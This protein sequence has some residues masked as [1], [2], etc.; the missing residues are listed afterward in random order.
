LPP[1]VTVAPPPSEAAV[2]APSPFPTPIS[3]PSEYRAD[4]G[5]RLTPPADI[6]SRP[7]DLRAKQGRSS[8]TEDVMSAAKSVFHAV[9]PESSN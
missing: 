5:L 4:D 8:V 1:A 6:P 3:G 2:S 9:V 7:L